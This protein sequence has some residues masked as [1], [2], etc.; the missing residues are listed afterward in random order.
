MKIT[1][2]L[3][4]VN[5]AGG[6]RSTLELANHLLLRGHEVSVV[7]PLIPLSSGKKWYNIRSLGNRVIEAVRNIIKGPGIEWFDLKAD[8][9]RVPTL[10]ERWIPK[11]DVMV[12]TWWENA[13][14]VHKFKEDKGE[15]F[16]F[17]RHYEIWG[18]PPDQ[19]KKTYNLPLNKIV[20]SNWLKNIMEEKFHAPVY[21]P[22]PNG[23]NFDLFHMERKTFNRHEPLKIG[24]L[25]RSNEFK[26]SKDGIKALK[27]VKELHPQVELIIFGEQ[28]ET[29]EIE[30]LE[31]LGDYEFH[32]MPFKKDLLKIYNSLDILLFPS[33][34]EGYGN[35]PLEAM[36]CGSA[37]VSTN[38][39]A[40]PDYSVDGDTIL[41]SSPGDPDALAGNVIKL[42]ENEDKR[43]RIA[44]NGH[45]YIK[46][47]T[48][49]NSAEELEKIFEGELKKRV[50]R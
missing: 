26:C 37:V 39:G 21:G 29:G 18:G 48:W 11:A 28:P 27:M 23:V 47:F 38:V 20:T 31:D 22:V 6:V 44:E 10:N 5:L 13:Y 19:V 25:Y 9:I 34:S 16:Y 41:T 2:I 7:Y 40:I 49:E 1:F 4:M 43:K 8:L 35:P 24:M 42:I 33:C 3:P 30:L 15:K 36:A 17:V 45:N 32:L 46:R 14:Q 50:D 12:A